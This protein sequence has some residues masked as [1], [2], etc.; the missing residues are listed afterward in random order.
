MPVATLPQ[1]QDARPDFGPPLF[2]VKSSALPALAAYRRKSATPEP[3]K[4]PVSRNLALRFV[5]G[6]LAFLDFGPMRRAG[7]TALVAGVF[8]LASDL[9][10]LTPP[11]CHKGKH[12]STIILLIAPITRLIGQTRPS[13]AV[14]KSGPE[15]PKMAR[16]GPF[17]GS[18]P[19]LENGSQ[20]PTG[21][22][23]GSV[24]APV[25]RYETAQNG[26]KWP[27][28]AKN[29]LIRER[30]KAG[31][32][33][34]GWQLRAVAMPDFSGD[35]QSPERGKAGIPGMPSRKPA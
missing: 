33:S 16:L 8:P 1:G 23:Y 9:S 22:P 15:R 21:V 12:P 11:P 6:S 4:G 30:R 32:I 13:P 18:I 2:R 14:P 26:P 20:W 29:S 19:Y 24:M 17:P 27:W 7:R 35:R 3:D 10:H 25:F 31:A 28:K 5:A 34:R